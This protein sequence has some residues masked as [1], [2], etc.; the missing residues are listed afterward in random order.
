MNLH[1]SYVIEKIEH[2]PSVVVFKW[3]NLHCGSPYLRKGHSKQKSRN[4]QQVAH[5][6]LG[7]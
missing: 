5:T 2:S 3:K 6:L 7:E 4:H 1:K